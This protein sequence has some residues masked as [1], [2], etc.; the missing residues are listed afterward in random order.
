[1]KISVCYKEDGTIYHVHSY[2]Y[3]FDKGIT[4][5]KIEEQIKGINE[6][7]GYEQFKTI[8]VSD[9]VGEI[10]TMLLGEK[11]YKRAKDIEDI[12]DTLEEVYSTISSVSR[13]IYD[14]AEACEK[15]KQAI[16]ELKASFEAQ[17]KKKK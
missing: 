1:M 15:S 4:E 8:E 9:E 12:L 17:N 5:E 7:S 14:A 2:D 13:D 16:E 11:K 10:I 3:Y 6:K